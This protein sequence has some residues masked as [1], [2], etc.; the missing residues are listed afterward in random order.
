MVTSHRSSA[1]PPRPT[2]KN[3]TPRPLIEICACRALWMQ[4]FLSTGVAHCC[5]D[6]HPIAHGYTMIDH[7]LSDNH[8][9][10]RR[11]QLIAC[12][13]TPEEIRRLLGNGSLRYCAHGWYATPNADDKA[14]RAIRAGGALTCLGAGHPW[15]VDAADLRAARA[16]DSAPLHEEAAAGPSL[17]ECSWTGLMAGRNRARNPWC[18][19]GSA[20]GGSDSGSKCRSTE[21]GAST[22][23]WVS[24]ASSRW[25]APSTTPVQRVYRNDRARDRRLVALGYVVVR[26][27]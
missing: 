4:I 25:T 23:S 17:I 3:C 11:A 9:I 20:G 18:G 16:P 22:C 10:V 7:L 15:R 21:W 1:Q 19:E 5:T 26:L 14:I 6:L 2:A 8:G 12:G 13:V 24:A 27:T